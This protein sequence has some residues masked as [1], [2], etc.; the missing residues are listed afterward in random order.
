MAGLAPAVRVFLAE[1][2]QD[3]DARDDGVGAA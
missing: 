3:V 1:A 2:P